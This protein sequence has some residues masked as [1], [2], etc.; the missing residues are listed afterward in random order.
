MASG[1]IVDEGHRC[2]RNKD[3]ALVAAIVDRLIYRSEITDIDGPNYRKDRR[4]SISEWCRQR[5]EGHGAR[6]KGL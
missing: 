6:R 2:S 3:T 4:Q 1:C 5:R